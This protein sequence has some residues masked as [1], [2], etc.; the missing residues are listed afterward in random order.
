MSLHA[1]KKIHRVQE[2]Q[3]IVNC[4]GQPRNRK[5]YLYRSMFDQHEEHI[6]VFKCTISR[7]ATCKLINEGMPFTCKLIGEGM[8]FTSNNGKKK[9]TVK[10]NM[11]CKSKYAI[12]SLIC[13]K[14]DDFYII[15]TSYNY[16]T[17]QLADQKSL[18][19]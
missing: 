4:K 7:C 19:P 3:K 5:E 12:Y 10:Q 8:P 6:T 11:H 13:D 9:F 18:F 15:Q 14:C 16:G 1:S 2:K 17:R